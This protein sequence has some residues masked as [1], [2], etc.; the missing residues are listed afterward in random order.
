MAVA[1]EGQH[2][3]VA[4]LAKALRF[5]ARRHQ[6]RETAGVDDVVDVDDIRDATDKR[7]R[8]HALSPRP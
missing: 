5:Q 3:P 2:G 8:R 7:H 4:A 1:Q 6:G